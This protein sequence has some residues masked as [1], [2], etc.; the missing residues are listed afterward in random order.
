MFNDWDGFISEGKGLLSN[1]MGYIG[2]TL[3]GKS[4]HEMQQERL[5][6]E[7]RDISQGDFLAPGLQQELARGIPRSDFRGDQRGLANMLMNQARGYGPGQE[8]VR[9]QVGQQ[10]A[11]GVQQQMGMLAGQRGNPLAAR[12]AAINM[13]N[14]SGQGGIAAATGGLQAQLGA[15]GQLG[16]VLQGARGQDLQYAG[17]DANRRQA[18]LQ[19]MQQG[20]QAYQGARSGRFGAIAGTPPAATSQQQFLGWLTGMGEAAATGMK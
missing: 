1:P 10:T 17:L 6:N 2:R 7:F 11:S 20:R 4:P 19:M 3:L 14:L 13:A 18:L 5:N 16:N 9:R 8:L 15:A 12:T